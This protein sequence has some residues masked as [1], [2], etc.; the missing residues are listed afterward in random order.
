MYIREYLANKQIT[1][2]TTWEMKSGGIDDLMENLMDIAFNAYLEKDWNIYPDFWKKFNAT[3]LLLE[4]SGYYQPK[5]QS[6]NLKFDMNK[7][8]YGDN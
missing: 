8:L 1:Q 6:V 5:K 4:M 2:K 3:K 7:I